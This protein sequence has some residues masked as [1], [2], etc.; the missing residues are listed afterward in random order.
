MVACSITFG[1]AA[2]VTM[3]GDVADVCGLCSTSVTMNMANN[4]RTIIKLEGTASF[5]ML[6]DMGQVQQLDTGRML[7]SPDM[8]NL[9]SPSAMFKDLDSRLCYVHLEPDNSAL[10]LHDST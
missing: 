10:V 6:T 3:K 8:H 9:L 1:S 5:V 2:T 4:S 7:I